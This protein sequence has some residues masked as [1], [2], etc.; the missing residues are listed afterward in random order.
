MNT[1]FVIDAYQGYGGEQVVRMELS[2]ILDNNM[3]LRLEESPIP[4]L[5]KNVLILFSQVSLLWVFR[6][7][8]YAIDCLLSSL[9]QLMEPFFDS[10]VL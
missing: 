9:H 5:T 4:V 8:Q 7:L 1:I 2:D 6:I 3:S 10:G